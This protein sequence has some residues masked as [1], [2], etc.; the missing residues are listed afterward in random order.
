M[1]VYV[2]DLYIFVYV[3]LSLLHGGHEGFVVVGLCLFNLDP[4][5]IFTSALKGILEWKLVCTST[6]IVLLKGFFVSQL[7]IG[8]A[9][10]M[11]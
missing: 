1:Y 5:G 7:I 3:S 11:V 9:Y 6:N 10:A 4:L 2:I 8:L